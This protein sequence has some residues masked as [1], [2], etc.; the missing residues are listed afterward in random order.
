MCPEMTKKSAPLKLTQEGNTIGRF[1]PSAC[2]HS[3]DDNRRTVTIHFEG[4][5]YAWTPVAGRMGFSCRVA[6]EYSIDFRMEEDATYVYA[7]NPRAVAGPDFHVASVENPVVDW[8]SK[9][10]AGYMFNTFGNQIVLNKLT[11]GFTV[12][13]TDE[14]DEFTL[15]HLAPPARPKKPFAMEDD[16]RYAYANETTE[17][18]NQQVDFLG[19]FE[20]ADEDQALFFRF[21]V[22][23]PPVDVLLLHRGTAD[24]W[25]DGLQRGAALAPP[26]GPV[27]RGFPV[28]PGVPVRQKVALPV[29]HYVAVIDN[30]NRVGGV[31]PPWNPLS[32]IG[33]NAA[34][35]SYAVELGDLD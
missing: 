11:S 2:S 29:G 20:V 17:V 6:V 25:R 24:L 10:P 13:H 22:Q 14:G 3:V 18:R 4:T 15:G 31:A 35:V 34:I 8:A 16:E 33:A 28:Q 9:T 1:F 27:L 7:T 21:H 12:V 26:P 23:G 30:S 32:V 19:P 5:G